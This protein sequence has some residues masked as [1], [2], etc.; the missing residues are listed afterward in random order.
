MKYLN[1]NEKC[2]NIV[3]VSKNFYLNRGKDVKHYD[4]DS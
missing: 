2:V 4:K 3:T 1:Y